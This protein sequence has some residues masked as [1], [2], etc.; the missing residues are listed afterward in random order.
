MIEMEFKT[1][2]NAFIRVPAQIIRQGRKTIYRLLAWNPWQPVFFAASTSSRRVC[3]VEIEVC[4]FVTD[5]LL[6]R[7]AI[8]RSYL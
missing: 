2:V 1:F 7:R 6:N 4:I 3:N 5:T 8:P